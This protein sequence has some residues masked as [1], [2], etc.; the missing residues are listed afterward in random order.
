MA[1]ERLEREKL[2]RDK[3]DLEDQLR[4]AQEKKEE[5]VHYL[6]ETRAIS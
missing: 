6:D 4:V 1:E 3:T 2:A 5:E